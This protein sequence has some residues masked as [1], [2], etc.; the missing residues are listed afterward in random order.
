LQTGRSPK[1][2]HTPTEIF[3]RVGCLFC[4]PRKNT[5]ANLACHAFN[6]IAMTYGRDGLLCSCIHERSDF[7]A[8]CSIIGYSLT[9]PEQIPANLG[10]S[11]TRVAG[12]AY[13]L[14]AEYQHTNLFFLMAKEVGIAP[15]L[16]RF[17]DGPTAVILLQ[18]WSP[19]RAFHSR[20]SAYRADALVPELQG[21]FKN[22]RGFCIVPSSSRCSAISAFR[23]YIS[24]EQIR[25]A[26]GLGSP[27]HQLRQC[28][29]LQRPMRII[30]PT[31]ST[32]GG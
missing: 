9:F 28:P 8:Q 11:F 2:S 16:H 5:P 31:P 22:V 24:L 23:A 27:A 13:H 14:G 32:H 12:I 25:W 30:G 7:I 6:A 3:R 10:E 19:R 17:G 29:N 4:I 21:H 15:T 1:L 20:T 18:Y 26:R